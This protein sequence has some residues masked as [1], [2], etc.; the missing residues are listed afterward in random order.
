MARRFRSADGIPDSLHCLIR[1]TLYP[2]ELGGLNAGGR[3]LAKSEAYRVGGAGFGGGN[4]VSKHAI[5]MTA[6]APVIPHG[7]QRHTDHLIA[8]ETIEAAFGECHEP[9]CDFK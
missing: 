5:G 2:E 1:E 3:R 4:I 6:S 7:E 8:N 9:L